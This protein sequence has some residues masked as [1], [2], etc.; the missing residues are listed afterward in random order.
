MAGRLQAMGQS[1]MDYARALVLSRPDSGGV[2]NLTDEHSRSAGAAAS[3]PLLQASSSLSV[4]ASD[5]A[6]PPPVG[7]S[8]VLWHP[9]VGS[10]NT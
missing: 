4:A 5:I 2:A 7:G 9:Q 3:E 1:A 8:D 10:H 6:E